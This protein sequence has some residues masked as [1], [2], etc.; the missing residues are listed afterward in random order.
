MNERL[1]V[2]LIADAW[3]DGCTG[4][5]EWRTEADSI[6]DADLLT[7]LMPMLGAGK[8]GVVEFGDNDKS[9][10]VL[11]CRR[12]V[13]MYFNVDK[14]KVSKSITILYVLRDICH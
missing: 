11:Q 6:T 8:C 2:E 10:I 4:S 13:H 5:R 3:M 9:D 14:I 12:I 1:D 7:M